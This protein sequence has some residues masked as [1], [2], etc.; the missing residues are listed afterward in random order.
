[1]FVYDDDDDS[2]DDDDDDDDDSDDDDDDDDSD[3]DD[4]DDNDDEN[5]NT[6]ILFNIRIFL[7]CEFQYIC[8]Y[9]SYTPCMPPPRFLCLWCEMIYEYPV[10]YKTT[11]WST[12]LSS[13]SCSHMT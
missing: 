11:A 10:L 13:T 2:D 1:M 5:Y 4:D 3:D 6:H 12:N 9:N 7:K 8:N